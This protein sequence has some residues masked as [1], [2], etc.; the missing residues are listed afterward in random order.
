VQAAREAA[1]RTA[2]TNNLRQIGIGLHHYHA[3]MSCFPPGGIEPR[4]MINPATGKAFGL[5]GR[6]LAWSAFLLPY[7]EQ[8]PLFGRIDFSR[9]FDAAENASAA[10]VILPVYICPS[11]PNGGDLRSG[12]GPCQYGGI[13]GER[14]TSPNNPPKGVMLYHRAITAADVRDGLSTT[15]IVAE[16]SD[17]A[18]GQWINGLNVF[19]QAYAINQAPAFEND[20]RSKH[21]GGANAAFCDG[22]VHFLSETMKME[23]LAALCTRAGDEIVGDF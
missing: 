9:A 13:Y 1:R 7:L 5:A 4:A 20:I 3:A 6:Q 21:P 17:F 18:D 15:L 10:A 14:I 19:D 12:R 11:V 22:A 16:D 2:C 8:E 23:T